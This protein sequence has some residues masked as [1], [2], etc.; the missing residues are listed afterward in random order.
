MKKILLTLVTLFV[1]VPFFANAQK[2]NEKVQAE[3]SGTWYDAKIIK[4]DESSGKYLVTYPG[5]DSGWDEWLSIEQLKDYA[6]KAP[7]GK[8][9]VGDKVEVEYGMIWEPATIEEVGENKY[10]IRFIK[11]SFGD[12]WVTEKQ[13]KKL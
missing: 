12:K 5:W 6:V 4:I 8:F 10:H 7:L 9:K 11:T 3:H 13:I 2:L 1:L